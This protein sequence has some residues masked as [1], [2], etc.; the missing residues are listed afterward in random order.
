MS[1]GI[2][3][4]AL[5]FL[6]NIHAASAQD[7]WDADNPVL[8]DAALLEIGLLPL[9]PG[10][11]DGSETDLREAEARYFPYVLRNVLERSRAWG[12]VRLIGS[13]EPG[14]EL[15]IHGRIHSS[16]PSQ[17]SLGVRVVDSLGETWLE[18]DYQA[19][20]NL[21]DYQ[22]TSGTQ[23][24]QSLY[25]AIARD[26][27]KARSQRSLKQLQRI[28]EVALVRYASTVVPTAFDGYLSENPDGTIRI[29]RLPA[30]NDPILARLRRVRDTYGLFVDAVDA[31]LVR[32]A[33]DLE[34]TYT[35]WREINLE[36]DGLMADYRE[37]SGSRNSRKKSLRRIYN[38]FQELNLYRETLR[39]SMA[40][41]AFEVGPTTVELDGEM[42]KLT[43]TL[44]YQRGQWQELLRK[45]YAAETGLD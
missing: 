45:I 42:I 6:A 34:P 32:H 2:L 13:A 21:A 4:A 28:I 26:V 43:G 19:E 39:E 22:E 9:E 12:P 38:E 25:E 31:S 15:T 24:F 3:L 30:S 37:Q 8:P 33:R 44:E 18:R 17:L 36:A 10:G 1:R 16:S 7:G 23:P 27:E 29:H 40:A 14:F 11:V 41:F 5:G 20:A 35:A